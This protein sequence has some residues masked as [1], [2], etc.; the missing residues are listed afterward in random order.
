MEP[1]FRWKA[2]V[3]TTFLKLCRGF[4]EDRDFQMH[5]N[6]RAGT[7]P[8]NFTEYNF[9]LSSVVSFLF[10]GRQAEQVRFPG[11]HFGR[12]AVPDVCLRRLYPGAFDMT[13]NICWT[14]PELYVLRRTVFQF[15]FTLG[16]PERTLPLHAHD[17]CPFMVWITLPWSRFQQLMQVALQTG[18]F[19]ISHLD[20]PGCMMNRMNF[21]LSPRS[22][23][24][25][26]AFQLSIS[27]LQ[28]ARIS[29]PPQ[30]HF[31]AFGLR[32]TQV[33]FAMWFTS[34][35]ASFWNRRHLDFMIRSSRLQFPLSPICESFVLL[36]HQVAPYFLTD[37]LNSY[38]EQAGVPHFRLWHLPLLWDRQQLLRQFEHEGLIPLDF[39]P[40]LS[41]RSQL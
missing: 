2:V 41:R 9:W 19:A 15:L 7:V 37:A 10:S 4:G 14:F 39:R 18:T 29:F 1:D 27:E 35:G 25:F 33:T 21:S 40:Q 8:G 20:I 32:L 31:I 17:W 5:S 12:T 23:L 16:T 24:L 28:S 22:S 30:D 13:P 34:Q 38:F 36:R 26:A 6:P 11:D 3:S